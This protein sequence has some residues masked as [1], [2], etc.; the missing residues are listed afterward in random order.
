MRRMI[1]L[2]TL[3]GVL[4][5][6]LVLVGPAS[7]QTADSS[8][9]ALPT[10]LRAQMAGEREV[11]GPGDPNGFGR[12]TII[13]IPPDT[14]CYVLTA[15]RIAPATAA[16]IHEAPPGEAGDVV[17]ELAP[18]TFGVSGGCT[19][20]DPE[21]VADIAANPSEYYVNVHNEPYPAGAIRGQLHR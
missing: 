15:R 2:L 13:L 3:A 11:P 10:V 20:A 21:L 4:A 19:S 14:I 8:D 18:P 9:L 16:H 17:V 7:A 5:T 6:M 1:V 12:A